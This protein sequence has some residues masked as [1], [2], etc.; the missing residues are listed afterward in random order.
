MEN[1]KGVCIE[2]FVC[3]SS[4]ENSTVLDQQKL[5][6]VYL[7]EQNRLIVSK[8][9]VEFFRNNCN[10]ND[11]YYIV[12]IKNAG[13]IM[14]ELDIKLENDDKISLFFSR[15]EK[16][17]LEGISDVFGH[18]ERLYSFLMWVLSV[19]TKET[20]AYSVLV[21]EAKKLIENDFTTIGSIEEL[22][23]S[24][25][26]SKH[27]LIREFSAQVGTSPGKFLEQKRLEVA[28]LLLRVS[29]YSLD[30]IANMVG[31]DNGNYLGKVFKKNV[32]EPP[33]HY[34]KRCQPYSSSQKELEI[35]KTLE[36]LYL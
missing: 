21:E 18:S 12:T 19:A 26:V 36:S 27:H 2:S 35:L 3:K 14:P 24:L 32:G 33:I 8:N 29:S 30:I 10:N 9:I 25:S 23:E 17:H 34:R 1:F 11:E 20:N 15:L 13:E 4:C 31:F 5:K 7:P 6:L 28:S 22:A 16:E